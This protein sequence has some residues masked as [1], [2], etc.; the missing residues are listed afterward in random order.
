MERRHK[1]PAT[2][3]KNQMERVPYR[4]SCATSWTEVLLCVINKIQVV[5]LHICVTRA[6]SSW[7]S[8]LCF[9]T[10]VNYKEYWSYADT[11]ILPTR[12]QMLPG[13][14]SIHKSYKLIFFLSPSRELETSNWVATYYLDEDHPRRSL[15]PGSGAAWSQRTGSELTPLEIDAFAFV[16]SSCQ[17]DFKWHRNVL[18]HRSLTKCNLNEASFSFLQLGDFNNKNAVPVHS[19]RFLTIGTAFPC[20][21]PGNDHWF[22]GNMHEISR[23]YLTVTSCVLIMKTTAAL[24]NNST[25]LLQCLVTG[26]RC[27]LTGPQELPAL[28]HH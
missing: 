23:S 13:D 24:A 12:F 16:V 20:V 1:A 9:K 4:H 6:R 15:F 25:P 17:P 26:H 22:S 28:V 5:Y 19:H 11:V 27:I 18:V 3:G 14:Y 7:I 2:Q 21:L 10:N 8:L